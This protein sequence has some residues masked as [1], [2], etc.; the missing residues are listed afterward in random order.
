MLVAKIA[1]ACMII[2]YLLAHLWDLYDGLICIMLCLSLHL[3]L[4]DDP[5][6]LIK[7]TYST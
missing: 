5:W 4:Q 7:L 2:V 1:L 3:A 6:T